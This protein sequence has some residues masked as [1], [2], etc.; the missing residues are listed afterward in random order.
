[1]ADLEELSKKYR[2]KG[3]S[4]RNADV[5]VCQDIVLKA[6]EKSEFGR[7]VTIKGGVVIILLSR[8]IRLNRCLSKNTGGRGFL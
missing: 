6:I 1:M 4:E 8:M 5:R 3:Y 2:E 7:N